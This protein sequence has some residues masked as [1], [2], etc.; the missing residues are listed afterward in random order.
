MRKVVMEV[1]CSRCERTEMCALGP[2]A[3]NTSIAP[4]A[5]VFS[6][7]LGTDN[8]VF[9]DLCTPCH[10][11]VQAMLG[12]IAKQVKGLSPDRATKTE[13][14]EEAKEKPP[15][16]KAPGANSTPQPAQVRAASSRT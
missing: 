9:D 2:V 5:P 10:R 6:A 7:R 4:P 15:A 11:T 8:V 13:V 14:K 3:E 1:Q 16:P 12:Q